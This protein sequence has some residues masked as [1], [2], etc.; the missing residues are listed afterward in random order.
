MTQ[1]A[2]QPGSQLRQGFE[3]KVTDSPA[4]WPDELSLLTERTEKRSAL[5]IP[6]K[7]PRPSAVFPEPSGRKKRRHRVRFRRGKP[8]RSV[9]KNR[10]CIGIT[11]WNRSR[12]VPR[13]RRIC[14]DT[15]RTPQNRAWRIV[16]PFPENGQPEN[17]PCLH[18]FRSGWYAL[19]EQALPIACQC[20]R[21]PVQS[22]SGQSRSPPPE[23]TVS[24]VD[25]DNPDDL[26]RPA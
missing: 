24:L 14:P 15:K 13:K 23:N 19:Q 3:K 11:Q 12:P 17:R 25:Q 22:A 5:P 1:R 8:E 18:P 7:K 26:S 6:Y 2:F 4:R 20:P 16:K 10:V 9:R 21:R